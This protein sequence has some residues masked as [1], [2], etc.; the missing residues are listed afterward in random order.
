M[1]YLLINAI[2]GLTWFSVTASAG[3]IKGDFLNPGDGYLITDTS[4]NLQWLTPYLTRGETWNDGTVQAIESNYGFH[5]ATYQQALDM[6]N[7][8]F[9]NPPVSPGSAAGFTDAQ[10]F[11]N[12]FGINEQVTCD[13]G[14]CPRTQGLTADVYMA[15]SHYAIGMLQYGSNGYLIPHNPWPDSVS[16]VQQGN[17]LI[18]STTASSAPE[19]GTL[20]LIG[21]GLTLCG[22]TRRSSS[23]SGLRGSVRSQ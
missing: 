3:L 21:V 15:G 13:V 1:K 9:N 2:V 8:N 6:I 11:F 4:T 22:L 23:R 18:R 5:Y 14:P 19:P 10:N 20:V 12:F 16:D 17:F 7:S